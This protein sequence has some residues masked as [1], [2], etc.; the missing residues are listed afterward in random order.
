MKSKEQV[1][2]GY[3]AQQ[4]R[5]MFAHFD[6]WSTPGLEKWLKHN[7]LEG[8]G[9]WNGIQQAK[10]V[11]KVL[12]QRNQM[13]EGGQDPMRVFAKGDSVKIDKP[14][15]SMHNKIGKVVSVKPAGMTGLASYGIRLRG[16]GYS[17]FANASQMK[18]VGMSLTQK[19]PDRK[20]FKGRD[21]RGKKLDEGSYRGDL[22]R[23]VGPELHI[24]QHRSKMG[25]DDDI[26]VVSFKVQGKEPANDLVS[27]LETGYDFI[28]DA[29][30]SPG[31]I[32]P[33]RFLVFFEI[34]YAARALAISPQN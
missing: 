21:Y 3:D 34:S 25:E 15:T 29:D 2:E 16:E 33:G 13:N 12:K 8:S 30:A 7:G 5:D 11:K 31:E 6:K 4:K 32:S 18:G 14:G 22:Q 20:H 27:F 23:L 26:I 19:T 28:L 9:D 24:D 1:D 10:V 17:S